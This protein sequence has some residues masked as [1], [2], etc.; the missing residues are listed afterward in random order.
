VTGRPRKIGAFDFNLARYSARVNGATQIAVT[1]LD[2]MF[3]E[4]ASVTEYDKLSEGA[5]AHVKKIEDEV[6]V[7]VTLISTGPNPEDIIDL[8]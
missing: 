3:P 1:C 6:G 4:C 2:R 8:R 5:K 7:R